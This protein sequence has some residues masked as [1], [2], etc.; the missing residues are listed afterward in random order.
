MDMHRRLLLFLAAGAAAV[1]A[2]SRLADA[3]DCPSRPI[4]L[5]V[6]FAA[7]GPAS[8]EARVLST[9]T[10]LD[11]MRFRVHVGRYFDFDP[12]HVDA[13]VIGDHGTSQVFL[14][15]SARAGGVSLNVQ[16]LGAFAK[17]AVFI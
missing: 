2:T 1:L 17:R 4:T 15:S 11:T 9:G 5:I 3:T 8:V 13:Q 14:W 7:G 12:A 6:G 16:A 10:F